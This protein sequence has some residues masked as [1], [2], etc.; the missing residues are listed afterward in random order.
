MCCDEKSRNTKAI[1]SNEVK[2]NAPITI[3]SLANQV[4]A[5]TKRN[6]YT[7]IYLPTLFIEREK[8]DLKSKCVCA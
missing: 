4:Y 6:K 3:E 8:N 7:E 5:H 2:W 1:F